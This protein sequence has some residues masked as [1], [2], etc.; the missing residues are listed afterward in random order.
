VS[1]ADS[2]DAVVRIRA[3]YRPRPVDGEGLFLLSDHD[4]H[5][6]E[7]QVFVDLC[8]LLAG[9]ISPSAAADELADAHEPAVTYY[10]LD[11]LDRGGVLTTDD[12]TGGTAV[13]L[14]ELSP[15]LRAA[16]H[17][18]AA[19][20]VVVTGL[21]GTDPAATVDALTACGIRACASADP[22]TDVLQVVLTTDYLAPEL[23]TIGRC[24]REEQRTWLLA[25]MTGTSL[26][27]GPWF[28]P[29]GPCY[30]CLAAALGTNRAVDRYVA[31]KTGSR[32]GLTGSAAQTAAH[33]VLVA[34]LVAL[35]TIKWLTDPEPEHHVR[36]VDLL[37]LGASEH[38][39]RQRPQCR[40][41]GDPDL[42]TR[43]MTT[44]PQLDV[45][46]TETGPSLADLRRLVSPVTGIV[47]AVQPT[48]SGLSSGH[49]A[50]AYCGFGGDATDLRGFKN[51]A[52]SQGAGVGT[53]A[54]EAEHG[55]LCE[56]LE[57]Y[58]CLTMGD[59]PWLLARYA[60][61]D[62]ATAVDPTACMLYS[63]R[64]YQ[65]RDEIN[66]RGAAFDVVP[67]PF[68]EHAPLAWTGMWSLSAGRFKLMPTSLL[69]YFFPQ[70]LG[71]YCWADSNGCA[72]G[73]SLADAVTRGLYELVERD[74][75]A[76][77][78]YNRLARPGLRLE[79][80]GD[81]ELARIGAE[82]DHLG[83]E[84]WALDLTADLGISTYVAISRRLD[85]EPEDIV[86]G[87]GANLDRGRALRHAVL[88]MNHILPAVLPAN[89]TGDGD[90]PYPEPAQKAWWRSATVEN[91]PY[92][93]PSS[94]LECLPAA[95]TGR[96]HSKEPRPL[97]RLL[98]TLDA[99]GLEVLV[100]DLTRPDVRLHVAKVIVPGLRHFWAR[101]APGR[102]YDVPVS[103]GWLSAPPL[104]E[105]L[106]PVSMFL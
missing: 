103:L 102:L 20:H 42:Q 56:A 99:A 67:E 81:P 12:E 15:D 74:A 55:A 89:R 8:G 83:R 32:V 59:E 61:L 1:A 78:W 41:C 79:V 16:R 87:F 47:S 58:S 5:F 98:T 21:P 10:A 25:R 72:A 27:I 34:G 73:T 18:L 13:F 19:A 104:E 11:L 63:D 23:E 36:V 28:T 101:L 95:E 94:W 100:L 6:F 82:H 43:L 52:I 26:W 53:T 65:Q 31:R 37:D 48:P 88:E 30:E 14:D 44:P 75:V 2:L 3:R 76:I 45:R 29:T 4:T 68:D 33:G 9:G 66:R 54:D 7:G 40:L 85:A 51:S 70:T 80:T 49:A 97:G 92:L 50:T 96:M 60:D 64:Q 69:F 91:Q 38:L 35:Q 93:L 105:D 57:R 24:N 77:W 90:Y 39:V 17:R 84:V 46:H 62:P 71:P 22:S 86:L 106:N